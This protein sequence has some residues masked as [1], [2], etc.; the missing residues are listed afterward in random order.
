VWF[1]LILNVAISVSGS[2]KTDWFTSKHNT[3]NGKNE[4]DK[5]PQFAILMV[6]SLEDERLFNKQNIKPKKAST[7]RGGVPNRDGGVS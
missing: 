4:V 5:L 3:D 7:G 6:Y 1:G 2:A